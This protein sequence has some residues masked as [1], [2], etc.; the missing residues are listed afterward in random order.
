MHLESATGDLKHKKLEV[1]SRIV[2]DIAELERLSGQ[3]V[4]VIRHEK[5]IVSIEAECEQAKR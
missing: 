2:Q 3:G 1:L 5:G 4:A